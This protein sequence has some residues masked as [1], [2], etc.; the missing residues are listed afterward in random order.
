MRP[1]DVARLD[2]LARARDVSRG[3]LIRQA[4]REFLERELSRHKS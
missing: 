4:V 1:A 2:A 3:A